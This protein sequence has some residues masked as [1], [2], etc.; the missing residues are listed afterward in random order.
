MKRTGIF[1]GSF[2][3]I[4]NGHIALARQLRQLA[5]LDEVWLMVSPQNPLKQQAGLMADDL[6]LRLARRALSGEPRIKVSDF[7][8]RLPRPSYTWHTLQ[9]LERAYPD[10]E[11]VLL[12]G[13]DN[14]Q[15]FHRW[16]RA[17][18]ILRRYAVVVYPRRGSTIGDVPKGVQV[19][20]ARLL[21]VS[22]TEVRRRVRRH[23]PID[24]LVPDAI[25]DDV[26]K[27]LQENNF[28]EE[29]AY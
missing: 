18:D 28:D 16:Y 14:W 5:Q 2:N 15:H 7:E 25:A 11:L 23:Q 3:P 26:Q 17:D 27:A 9:A 29:V 6:R 19:V 4:H 12:I 8:F 22:S 1:G 24:G 10:R 20:K 13:G 21:D